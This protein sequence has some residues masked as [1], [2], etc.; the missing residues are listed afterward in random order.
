MCIVYL[1][2]TLLEASFNAD[3]AAMR[4]SWMEFLDQIFVHRLH[5]YHD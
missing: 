5:I 2:N 1:F 3:A 4:A